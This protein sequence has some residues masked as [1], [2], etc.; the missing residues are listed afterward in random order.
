MSETVQGNEEIQGQETNETKTYTEEQLKEMIAAAL[1][2][3]ETEIETKKKELAGLNRRVGE[4]DKSLKAKEQE[5]LS[6]QERLLQRM[7][8]IEAESKRAKLEA[9]LIKKGLT[10]DAVDVLLSD[11]KDAIIEYMANLKNTAAQ[12]T[13]EA[14]KADLA[15]KLGRDPESG[16]DS[17]IKV[18][19]EKMKTSP[20]YATEIKRKYPALY[21]KYRPK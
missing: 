7:E 10:E 21:E 18:D 9:S 15:K 17:D 4:L 13:A 2:D 19:V 12:S 11:D 1:Q 20:S 14:V 6:E 5:G 8:A 16:G 3:K